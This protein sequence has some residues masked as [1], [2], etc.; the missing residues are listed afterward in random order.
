MPNWCFT[1]YAIEG[2]AQEVEKLYGIMK[3][4]GERKEPSVENGFGTTW[5]GCLLDALGG[6]CK[7]I[8]CR[9]NW[10]ELQLTDNVLRFNTVTAWAPC[11]ATFDFICREFPSLHCYYQAEEPN[12][13]Y[14][15]TNDNEGKYFPDR[16]IVRLYTPKG[17]Y[18]DA[19]FSELP[20]LLEWLEEKCGQPLKS[21]EDVANM[22]EQWHTDNDEAFCW[23]DEY[24]LER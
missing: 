22:L 12:F 17:E 8:W 2:N 16:Y 19:T 18:Y 14:Y 1:A 9:G 13:A 10:G 3:E 24:E 4:L 11:F 23:V 5:L 21:K 6:D 15:G 7:K 20:K